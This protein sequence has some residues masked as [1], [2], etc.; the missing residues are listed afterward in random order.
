MALKNE[1]VLASACKMAHSCPILA[2]YA[3]MSSSR[4]Q[5]RYHVCRVVTYFTKNALM[6][7]SMPNSRATWHY[8]VPCATS[9]SLLRNL[10]PQ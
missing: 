8:V 7:S 6:V 1:P 2:W 3:S 4:A 9:T 10:P 5:M